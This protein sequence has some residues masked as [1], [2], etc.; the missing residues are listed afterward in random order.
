MLLALPERHFMVA[1]DPVFFWI[2]DKARYRTWYDTV[3][4]PPPEPALLLRASFDAQFVLCDIR[5]SWGRIPPRGFGPQPGSGASTSSDRDGWTR[6]LPLRPGR[7]QTGFECGDGDADRQSKTI[8]PRAFTP[9]SR[10]WIACG[11][12]SML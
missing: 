12:S 9:F 1:L 8:T 5:P 10:S 7:P 4:D 6:H 2:L 11:A 3:H